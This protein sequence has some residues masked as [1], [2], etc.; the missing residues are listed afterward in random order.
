MSTNISPTEFLKVATETA[1]YF[2]FQDLETLKK[3]PA[4]KECTKK[5]STKNAAAADRKLDALHGL[6]TRGACTYFEQKL[7]NIEGPVL[8]Y[9]IDAV[10][11]SGETSFS[12]HILNVE[13]SIAE[14]MLIQTIRTL[15]NEM[16]LPNHNIR[17]NSLGD[18]D[19]MARYIRELTAFLRKR[20]DTLPPDAREL[21]KEHAFATLRRLVE[22]NDE[23]VHKTP[24]S[25]EY[26]SD[27]SRKH[28][29]EIV[30]FLDMSETMYE[31]DS[32]LIG[33]HQCYSDTLFAVD[34]HDKNFEKLEQ[35]P[36]YIRGGRYH[37]FVSRM[38][39]DPVPAAGAVVVLR[40]K[41]APARNPR[42]SKPKNPKVFVVQI[43]FGPKVRS[44]LLVNELKHA[45]I[46]ATQ[47][48]ISDSLSGQLHKAEECGAKYAVII[49]QKEFVDKTAIVRNL[50]NQTQEHV[51]LDKIVSHLKR[52]AR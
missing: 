47:D 14:T 49:G 39:K 42:P 29:R 15:L 26:L 20:I 19:S 28:F 4:C 17:I 38:T 16:N 36:L 10:P 44:L 40:N 52:V 7:N 24:S 13:K 41:K 3:D 22:K 34:V 6:L 32:K 8:L 50:K 5:V 1:Q 18:P 9:S 30:E 23:L 27:P 45:G 25:L 48:I 46:P 37:S 43:G 2:G 11:R 21:M 51:P 33:H 35:Q 12:F 31:I